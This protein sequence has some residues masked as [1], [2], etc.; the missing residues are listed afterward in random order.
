MEFLDGITLREELLRASGVSPARAL[1][2]MRDVCAAI[3][4]AHHRQLVHRDLKPEN[5]VLVKHGHTEVAKVVDFGVAT[6]LTDA[7]DELAH[8]GLVGTLRYMAP[9]QLCSGATDTGSDIWALGV[10]AYELLTGVHPFAHITFEPFSGTPY[11]HAGARDA[12]WQC[13][14]TVERVLRISAGARQWT[15]TGHRV[16]VS[17]GVRS[18]PRSSADL[19]LAHRG[20]YERD[21]SRAARSLRDHS[22][23]SGARGRR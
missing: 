3:E 17:C 9:A 6:M 23:E 22:V 21:R 12:A 5:I 4:Q 14:T 16:T 18:G 13:A 11:D 10:M 8:A 20:G 19:K 7:P 2:I 1:A 15:T